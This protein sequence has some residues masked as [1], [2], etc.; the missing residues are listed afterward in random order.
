MIL[1]AIGHPPKGL[2]RGAPWSLSAAGRLGHCSSAF[3]QLFG[4]A[5][6]LLM[7][8]SRAQSGFLGPSRPLENEWG[9]APRHLLPKPIVRQRQ[10]HYSPCRESF[11]LVNAQPRRAA[12]KLVALQRPAWRQQASGRASFSCGGRAAALR[13]RAIRQFTAGATELAK[14]N[15]KGEHSILDFDLRW[16]QTA[17][18]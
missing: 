2:R 18:T 4:A 7:R 11:A 10:G 12:D 17:E 15:K 13:L 14:L 16:T 5:P 6:K 1:F 9:P 3:Q 8:A